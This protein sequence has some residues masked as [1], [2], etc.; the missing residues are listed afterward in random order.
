MIKVAIIGCGKIADMHAES[1]RRVPKCQIVGACDKEILMAQQL[2]ER[3]SIPRYFDDAAVMLETVKPD[4][5]HITTPPQS[6][7]NLGM[8]C[9]DAGCHIYVEKPFTMNCSEV[10]QLLQRSL[11]KKRKVTVGHNLQFSHEAV[12]MRKLVR[13]GFLGSAPV[14]ME[15]YYCYNLDRNYAQALFGDKGHW[16]RKLPGKLLHN[17]ISH[18]ISRIT[19]FLPGENPTVTVNGFT[20]LFLRGIGETEIIDELRVIINDNDNVTAYF[21][22]STQMS[23]KLN[24]FRIY[25]LEN[26]IVVDHFH[27]S[28]VRLRKIKLKS[29]MNYF[30]SPFLFG[31]EYVANS[32]HN[33]WQFLKRNFHD[34]SGMKF[35]IEAFYRSIEEDSEPPISYREI[36]LTSKIM[37]EIFFQLNAQT[38]PGKSS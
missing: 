20:S 1:I 26:G 2:A 36:R 28:L 34:D 38:I 19:E 4:V 24:Q 17:I 5:V 32:F 22:F 12:R 9:L 33:I 31:R 23:P 16:V 13:E 8:L 10:E 7:L 29:Y 6:H 35:L 18:G 27:R 14:H 30:F 15:S 37:D 3:Y 21:T 25:G 11:E